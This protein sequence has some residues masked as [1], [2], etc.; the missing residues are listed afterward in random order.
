MPRIGQTAKL[1]FTLGM[2]F[3]AACCPARADDPFLDELAKYAL[4][5]DGMTVMSGNAMEENAAKQII[6]PWPANVQNRNIAV[7]GQ[8]MIGA[9]DRYQN[10]TK[11]E[12]GVRVPTLKPIITQFGSG[13]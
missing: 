4:R 2:L 3:G 9:M 13:Q 8:R 11:V 5:T 10:P 7:N 12:N 6:D 1:G